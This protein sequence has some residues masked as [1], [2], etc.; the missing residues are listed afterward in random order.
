MSRGQADARATRA[1]LCRPK[2][3]LP[4][5]TAFNP[6]CLPVPWPSRGATGAPAEAR[7]ARYTNLRHADLLGAQLKCD[8]L[9]DL[10]ETY[11]VEV[12][13]SYDRT[14]EGMADEYHA[15]IPDLGLQL[16]FDENQAL[17][18]L[19]VK[20]RDVTGFCPL[21]DLADSSP[22]FTSLAEAQ[23][24]ARDTGA[25]ATVGSAEFL[26]EARDW[27]RFEHPGYSV[28]YE[29]R[30]PGLSLVTFQAQGT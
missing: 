4:A 21:A 28:H 8:F 30:G 22:V 24:H 12:A 11:D 13:Y 27:I 18:T 7:T 20:P 14:H 16:S 1:D 3:H 17:K 23:Q 9:C 19:F 25:E 2:V 5:T 15:A 6:T 10:F 29:F 26:G